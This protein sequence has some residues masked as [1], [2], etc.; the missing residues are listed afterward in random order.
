MTQLYNIISNTALNTTYAVNCDGGF[1]D[2][3]FDNGWRI[4]H[5]AVTASRCVEFTM[6][7]ADEWSELLYTMYDTDEIL[8]MADLNKFSQYVE[9]CSDEEDDVLLEIEEEEEVETE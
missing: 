3:A 6:L 2:L 5:H 4:E 7:E 9:D 8:L 1:P